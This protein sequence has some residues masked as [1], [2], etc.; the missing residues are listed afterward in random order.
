MGSLDS[1]PEA[2]VIIYAISR[3]GYDD[4]L[5]LIDRAI[6]QRRDAFDRLGLIEPSRGD[7]VEIWDETNPAEDVT[8][9]KILLGHKLQVVG[10]TKDKQLRCRLG[11]ALTTA[12]RTYARGAILKVERNWVYRVHYAP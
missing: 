10:Y 11:V 2:Q 9:P 6:H 12:T 4:S 8:V 5:A 1:S 3:G 7:W